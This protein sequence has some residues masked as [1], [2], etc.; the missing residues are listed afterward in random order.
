MTKKRKKKNAFYESFILHSCFVADKFLVLFTTRT[1]GI[2]K[3]TDTK[4]VCL[5]FVATEV[6]KTGLNAFARLQ[7][8][9]LHC[10]FET[11]SYMP[12][13]TLPNC[14]SHKRELVLLPWWR[15]G[16]VLIRRSDSRPHCITPH[17]Y[18]SALPLPSLHGIYCLPV[19]YNTQMSNLW[20]FLFNFNFSLPIQYFST[21]THFTQME[22]ENRCQ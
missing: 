10:N 3:F 9:S 22:H 4:D 13:Y 18:T 7:K 17:L 21:R 12:L 2:H 8:G 19:R 20:I 5:I 6:V 14:V 11:K 15:T 1:L 16:L